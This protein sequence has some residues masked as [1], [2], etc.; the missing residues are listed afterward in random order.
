MVCEA[1]RRFLSSK[2]CKYARSK[3][4]ISES[5]FP[6]ILTLF[7]VKRQDQGQPTVLGWLNIK[8]NIISSSREFCLNHATPAQKG[9]STAALR[10]V[11]LGGSTSCFYQSSTAAPATH[12]HGLFLLISEL[13]GGIKHILTACSSVRFLTL[14]EK[15]IWP[16]SISLI[17]Y[18][19]CR[20]AKKEFIWWQSSTS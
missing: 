9:S 5:K 6:S 16:A 18:T 2:E 20:T 17:P 10:P 4:K 1:E 15:S 14:I 11:S 3:E 8:I 12:T 7:V 19:S 13:R